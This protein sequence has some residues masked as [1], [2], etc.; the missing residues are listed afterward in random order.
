MKKLLSTIILLLTIGL[1]V[2]AQTVSGKVVKFTGAPIELAEIYID[3][4]LVAKSDASG[5][6]DFDYSG[7]FPLTLHVSAKGYNTLKAVARSEN[8]VLKVKFPLQIKENATGGTITFDYKE[9]DRMPVFPGCDP[10]YEKSNQAHCFERGITRCVV[11]N[12]EYPEEAK[13]QEI[14]GKVYVSFVI[15]SKGKVG[16]IE[17]DESV[18]PLLDE[19][20]IRLIELVP[21]MQAAT[22]NNRKVSVKYTLP[23][24]FDLK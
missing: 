1:H 20:A 22:L 23:V 13:S 3:S 19:E 4:N 11:Q 10:A 7:K 9:V 16:S 15:N 12:F 2:T 17:I 24:V 6:F 5:M 14:E 21:K 8:D 18:H